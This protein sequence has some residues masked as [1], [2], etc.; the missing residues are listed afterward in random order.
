MA[1]TRIVETTRTLRPSDP[2]AGSAATTAEAMSNVLAAGMDPAAIGEH[3]VRAIRSGEFYIFTHPEWGPMLR[4]Q[5]DEMLEGFGEA[6][7]PSYR[8]DDIAGL[9]AANG[10][11]PFV[12]AR[13]S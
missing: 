3:V 9:I 4:R 11:R 10:G 13:R 1:A 7:D 5:Y 6:S 12:G 8:G 2:E